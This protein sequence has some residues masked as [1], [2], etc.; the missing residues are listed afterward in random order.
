VRTCPRCLR[1][2]II[3]KGRYGD[4]DAVCGGAEC[5]P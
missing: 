3:G 1:P 2:F 4:G 5:L